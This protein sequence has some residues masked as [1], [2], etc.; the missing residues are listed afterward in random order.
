[1]K[2]FTPSIIICILFLYS[3]MPKD[4]YPQHNEW[5]KL[6]FQGGE[7][8]NVCNYNSKPNILLASSFSLGLFIS[9][10]G[11]ENWVRIREES[12]R[13]L[14][15]NSEDE[16]FIA[17]GSGLYKSTDFGY[18]WIKLIDHETW[19][20][21]CGFNGILAA[22]TMTVRRFNFSYVKDPWLISF[23][24]GENWQSWN[25][26]S[27]T[28]IN[29]PSL[30]DVKQKRGSILFHKSG[31]VFR[32]EETY[33]FISN[34][35]SLDKWDNLGRVFESWLSPVL[36]FIKDTSDSQTIWAFSQYIDYHPVGFIYGGIYRSSDW[37]ETWSAIPNSATA[38]LKNDSKIFFGDENGDFFVYE[39]AASKV[40]KFGN[41]GGKITSI[42]FVPGFTDKIIFSSLGGIFCSSDNGKTIVKSDNGIYSPN[43]TSVGTV[44]LDHNKERIICGTK[45]SGIWFSD[46]GGENWNWAD[47]N[48]YIVPELLKA[49]GS[50]PNIL[51]AGGAFIYKSTDAG[52]SWFKLGGPPGLYYY[53]WYGR[54]YDLE[55]NPVQ[56]QTFLV[57]YSDHSMD[58]YLGRSIFEGT[59]NGSW[60]WKKFEYDNSNFSEGKIQYHD[61]SRIW[62][63]NLQY[64]TADPALILTAFDSDSV[65][66][67]ITLPDSRHADIW[68]VS[69]SLCFIYNIATNKLWSSPDLG[70]T[71]NYTEFNFDRYIYDDWAIEQFIGEIRISPDKKILYF[72]YP[73]G[74]IFYSTNYGGEWI[75]LN[76]G[77]DSKEVFQ[78]AFSKT[79]P[80]RIYSATNKGLFV[81]DITTSLNDYPGEKYPLN[82]R[83]KQNYPNPFNPVTV[84]GYEV[85]TYSFVTL[86][87]YD[88]L[89]REAASLV[90]EWKQPG[91]YKAVFDA[92]NLASGLYLYRLQSDGSFL[93]NKMILTK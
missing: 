44:Q 82:F 5:I 26:T 57:N 78:L 7:I 65:L 41:V 2:Q 14:E 34:I 62:I 8:D 35:D 70:K 89:G 9:E 55:V 15:I 4:I 3:L 36:T 42:V 91:K 23:D 28:G 92:S 13:D 40:Q 73:G 56:P 32:A 81:R 37:G 76:E 33:I 86:K 72:L 83:L 69:D 67:R 25:G 20:V 79:N 50:D 80:G 51:Y 38:I 85:P 52:S 60:A 29:M 17:T 11:G 61:S 58:H 53:G 77:L 46:D 66:E 24:S 90:N 59:F 54:C 16:A 22:D 21:E 47:T 64:Q 74:G 87:V 30:S 84:I 48:A 1:M 71:W 18:S 68:L 75:E 39:P 88:L 93:T 27:F 43:L 10:N 45:N 63:S 19:Q 49:S 6:P 12:I 31:N